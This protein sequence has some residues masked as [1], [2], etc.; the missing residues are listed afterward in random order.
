MKFQDFR[1]TVQLKFSLDY[2]RFVIA[3]LTKAP[4]LSDEIF[5]IIT[6]KDEI[7]VIAKEGTELESISEEKF[8]KRII[9]E[10]DLPFNLTGFLSHISTLL[11]SK[12]IP[13]FIISG[14]STDYL[15][16]K[17]NILD[18]VVKLLQKDNFLRI[19]FN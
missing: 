12:N 14:Y 15:F 9:F 7:T 6:D 4:K 11:A 17:E 2:N 16:V 8:F 13:I 1:K 3:K 19:K 10:V 18:Q 5:S